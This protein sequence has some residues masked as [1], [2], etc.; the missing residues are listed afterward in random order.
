[1]LGLLQTLTTWRGRQPTTTPT[2]TTWGDTTN[3]KQPT[4][5]FT[6]SPSSS[7]LEGTLHTLSRGK[8]QIYLIHKICAGQPSALKPSSSAKPCPCL[9]CAC[10]WSRTT[11]EL[12][13]TSSVS[14][15]VPPS[16]S[17]PPHPT[18]ASIEV[19]LPAC[20]SKLHARGCAL[21][22]LFSLCKHTQHQ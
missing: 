17:D 10:S 13:M 12:G 5:R 6:S 11:T 18:S 1:M 2:F 4:K 22:P 3:G 16:L 9:A 21:C 8:T 15:P 7:A 20:L 14:H 19:L